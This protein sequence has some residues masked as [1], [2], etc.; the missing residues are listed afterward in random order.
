MIK[1]FILLLVSLKGKLKKYGGIDMK[2]VVILLVLGMFTFSL[3]NCTSSKKV[4]KPVEEPKPDTTV[5]APPPPPTKPKPKPQPKPTEPTIE[6]I[7][8][9]IHFDFDSYEIR[10]DA[11]PIL[12]RIA[13]YLEKHKD[14]KLIIEGHCDERGTIEYNQALGQKRADAVKDYFVS[15]GLSPDRFKTISY[16]ELKPI[17][18][19]HNEEAYAKNRRVH[20]R[21]WK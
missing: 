4:T 15:Y 19:R 6:E 1:K 2:K 18:P 17:D 3:Y 13:K 10:P 5:K 7:L 8:E 11:I 20:F 21:V 16:G 9:D 12:N 14:I